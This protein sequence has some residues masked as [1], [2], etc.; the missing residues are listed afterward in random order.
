M[1]WFTIW[2]QAH[3]VGS[4]AQLGTTVFNTHSFLSKRCTFPSLDPF[5]STPFHYSVRNLR[6]RP[7]HDA[8][9]LSSFLAGLL[10]PLLTSIQWTFAFG[11]LSHFF[12]CFGIYCRGA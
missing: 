9:V 5:A 11:L 2:A 12:S 3:L 1:S 4:I 7:F 10:D 8:I 6:C